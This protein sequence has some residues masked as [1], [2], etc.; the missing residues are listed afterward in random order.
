MVVLASHWRHVLSIDCPRVSAAENDF[1]LEETI[2]EIQA[3]VSAG[4]LS[5]ERLAELYLARIAAYDRAGP[6]LNSIIYTSEREGGS[7]RPRQGAAE[8]GPRGPC[9][10]FLFCSRIM[11]T[12]PTC[13]PRTVPLS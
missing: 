3:A 1:A 10:A 9:T 2:A 4:A 13:R 6:R 7:S 11:S 12:S 8:K 5:S